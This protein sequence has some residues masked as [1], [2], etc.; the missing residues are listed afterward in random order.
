MQST[1]RAA[2]CLWGSCCCTAPP[3]RTWPS[4]TGFLP[5]P[6]S[7]QG[8]PARHVRGLC[9]EIHG[10]LSAGVGLR[11]TSLCVCA[12]WVLRLRAVS[13]HAA[14]CCTDGCAFGGSAGGGPWTWLSAYCMVS[15]DR[16]GVARQWAVWPPGGPLLPLGRFQLNELPH[17]PPQQ[18]CSRSQPYCL[19]YL[20]SYPVHLTSTHPYCK[21][22]AAAHTLPTAIDMTPILKNWQVPQASFAPKHQAG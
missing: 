7:S 10:Q 2:R 16:T 4:Q 15:P 21:A 9:E 13:V 11:A 17:V 22:V 12:G 5:P 20:P 1:H 8:G 14:R 19:N 6:H 3:G 18:A